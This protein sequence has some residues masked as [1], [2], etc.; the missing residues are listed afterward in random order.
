MHPTKGLSHLSLSMAG[1]TLVLRPLVF[2]G[3]RL[4]SSAGILD[5]YYFPDVIMEF[6]VEEKTE[7]LDETMHDSVQHPEKWHH[8]GVAR[9][10]AEA[11]HR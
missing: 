10:F 1:E 6:Q 5:H 8:F 7:S 2:L 4:E 3:V 11:E 9:T